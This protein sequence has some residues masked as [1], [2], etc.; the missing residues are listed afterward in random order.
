ME[1]IKATAQFFPVYINSHPVP[2]FPPLVTCLGGTC[3]DQK[4]SFRLTF[5]YPRHF[6]MPSFSPIYRYKIY[7][8]FLGKSWETKK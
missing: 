2:L 3:P 7:E 8:D 6:G 4:K 5:D 1:L